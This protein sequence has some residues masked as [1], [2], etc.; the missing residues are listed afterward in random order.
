[1]Q[2]DFFISALKLALSSKTLY[3]MGCFGSP[4]TEGNKE[5]YK[6]NHSYNRQAARRAMIDAADAN[7]FGFDC[8]NLIKAVLWGWNADLS[9]VYGGAEYK[10]NGVPDVSANQM[11][12]YC[13]Q[14]ADF[15]SRQVEKGEFVWMD[16]HCGIYVGD[17]YV[18]E[19]T[20]KWKNCVQ[21]TKLSDRVW[22]KHGFLPWVDYTEE[23]EEPVLD[24]T[25]DDWAKEACEWCTQEGFFSGDDKGDF[26]WHSTV[27]RQEL[28]QVIYRAFGSD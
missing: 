21:K 20:P 7:T 2:V 9:D 8:V 11:I 27:T 15:S 28:A 1:M 16:G 24:N 10:S 22:L 18:I 6:N 25:P 26:K 14:V 19:C 17:G 4:M 23:P 12:N 5:R 3:V 13:D